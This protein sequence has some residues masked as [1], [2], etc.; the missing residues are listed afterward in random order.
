MPWYKI[1]D[2][3]DDNFQIANYDWH[4]KIHSEWESITLSEKQTHNDCEYFECSF[5]G[6]IGEAFKILKNDD[7]YIF[8]SK[9]K[10]MITNKQTKKKLV[11]QPLF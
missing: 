11:V 1:W 6:H 3:S 10:L 4:A 8:T 9:Y 2:L 7:E 5:D